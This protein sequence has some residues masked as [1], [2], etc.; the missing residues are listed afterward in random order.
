MLVDAV[1]VGI[2]VVPADA[3]FGLKLV[4]GA[5]HQRTADSRPGRIDVSDVDDDVL[6]H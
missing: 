6:S 4:L 2:K 5:D 3:V 1:L